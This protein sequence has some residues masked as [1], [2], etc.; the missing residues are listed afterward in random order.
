ME[1]ML[2]IIVVV[3]LNLA[4]PGEVLDSV[5]LVSEAAPAQCEDLRRE[6]VS[7]WP[8]PQAGFQVWSWC[9]GTENIE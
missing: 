3:M 6:V 9:V 2:L 8:D 5:V 7:S 1:H 4:A